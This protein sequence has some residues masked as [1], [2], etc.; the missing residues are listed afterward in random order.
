[1]KR[2]RRQAGKDALGRLGAGAIEL[3]DDA[4]VGGVLI[5]AQQNAVAERVCRLRNRRGW[6]DVIRVSVGLHSLVMV[7]CFFHNLRCRQLRY[8]PTLMTSLDR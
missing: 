6:S 7:N 5:N 8:L 2:S 3:P 4:Q 1:M